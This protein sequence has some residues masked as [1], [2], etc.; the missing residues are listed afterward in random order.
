MKLF[1]RYFNR[2]LTETMS[3]GSVGMAQSPD[4]PDV[5]QFSADTYAPGLL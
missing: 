1:E 5:T 2:A 4:A 3:C